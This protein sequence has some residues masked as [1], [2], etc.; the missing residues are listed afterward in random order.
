MSSFWGRLVAGLALVA[1]AGAPVQA[2][3]TRPAVCTA[4]PKAANLNFTLK[5]LEGRDINLSAY[6]G[7]V[8][9]LDF[10]ATWCGPCKVEI[11]WFIEFY[12]K[13]QT[14]GL[15]V[16]GV[17][18]DD[19]V[20]SLKSYAQQMKMN[21]PILVSQE[22]DPIIDAFGPMPGLPTTFVIGRDGRI[23]TRHTGLAEKDVFEA[24]IKGLL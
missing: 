13:Y 7:K 5:D 24:A 11:P 2:Q 6:K 23:C 21:Y 9:L 14:Q 10:W 3:A 20:A 1:V 19:P 22:G 18:V 4:E 17:A 12:T 15:Q 16:V 8:V